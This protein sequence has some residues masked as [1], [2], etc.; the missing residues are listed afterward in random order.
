MLHYLRHTRS[1][2]CAP[3]GSA[4]SRAFPGA[5]VTASDNASDNASDDGGAVGGGAVAS[6]QFALFMVSFFCVVLLALLV[7]LVLCSSMGGA[8]FVGKALHAFTV[9]LL[10]GAVGTVVGRLFGRRPF[11]ILILLILST[12]QGACAMDGFGTPM[13]TSAESLSG[14]PAAAFAAGSLFG[15]PLS[16][17]PQR[18]DPRPPTCDSVGRDIAQMLQT[19]SQGDAGV[20]QQI[21]SEA[22]R[23]LAADGDAEYWPVEQADKAAALMLTSLKGY[24]TGP[25]GC[26]SKGGT[27][28]TDRSKAL[29]TIAAALHS[30]EVVDQ[31]LKS[32]ARRLSGLTKGMQEKGAS[33][34]ANNE[35]VPAAG[36]AVGVPRKARFDKVDLEFIYD[37]FHTQSPDVEPDK[38]TKFTY[39]RK[40]CFCAGKQRDL[41]CTKKVL[42]CSVGEAVEHC[43]E[44]DVFRNS[45]VSLHP[46]NVAACICPCIKPAKRHECVCPI[47]NEFIEALT[48]YNRLRC[49]WHAAHDKK[50][51]GECGL[52]CKN[53]D[54]EFRAFTK[55]YNTFEAAIRCPKVEHPELAL[56]HDPSYSPEFY[57]LN[58]CLKRG[59][60]TGTLPQ[61]VRPCKKCAPKRAQ[62]LPARDQRCKDELDGNATW[63]RYKD[64]VLEDG[65][66]ANKLT[67]HHGTRAELVDY[68]KENAAEWSFHRWVKNWMKWQSK[69]NMAT[70]DG[71]TEILILADYA[72]VYEMK[73]RDSRTCEHGTTCN[74]LVALVLHSPSETLA[75]GDERRVQCDYWR[76][77]S[78]QKGN[79]EQ[80]RLRP[81][82]PCRT[83][84]RCSHNAPAPLPARA[85]S[86]TWPC[87][88]SQTFTNAAVHGNP[89]KAS[90]RAP[91]RTGRRRC[92]A[93]CAYTSGVMGNDRSTKAR[94][95][96]AECRLGPSR[97]M[98]VVWSWKYT[99][100]CTSHTTPAA[101]RTMQERTHGAPW[102]QPSCMKNRQPYMTIIGAWSGQRRTWSVQT[103]STHTTVRGVATGNIF[104][105]PSQ[106]ERTRIKPNTQTL[107]K[108]CANG[109][110]SRAPTRSTASAPGRASTTRWSTSF[111][112]PS[113]RASVRSAATRTTLSATTWSSRPHGMK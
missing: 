56:P 40:R 13:Q 91:A 109:M 55:N 46:K 79:A 48:A 54:S 68:I 60:S 107:A 63:M 105:A 4:A 31:R 19:V 90:T 51:S 9:V 98:P 108:K 38:T 10:H 27:R 34:R 84:Y 112:A 106:T 49:H 44:S 30:D 95:T 61:D 73:G 25:L 99:I 20:S 74:Q 39:K 29:D 86:T 3:S 32:E 66:T 1:C 102:T 45:G 89:T 94:R 85:L 87:E 83:S 92:R 77:W 7:V 21:L 71:A 100:T 5:W 88:K 53:P 28:H 104:G 82:L 81:R 15:M 47:C 97:C 58:C 78:N 12:A 24:V 64:I 8:S 113:C 6:K 111:S 41:K 76:F 18:T 42:T 36:V 37:W 59:G 69:L 65:K 62:L 43:M 67:E 22:R 110:P 23:H 14:S 57:K 17:S 35:S 75:H 93:C 72:A 70:F 52:Q 50:C 11:V 103:F 2:A 26:S 16:V 101:L 33:L 96:S 80:V